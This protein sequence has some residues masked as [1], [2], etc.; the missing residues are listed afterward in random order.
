MENKFFYNICV[1]AF[2]IIYMKMVFEI[3]KTTK[4]KTF[5]Y[6]NKEKNSIY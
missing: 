2:N 5:F 3:Y 6:R 1:I 4:E